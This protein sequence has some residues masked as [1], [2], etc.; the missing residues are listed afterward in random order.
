MPID[1]PAKVLLMIVFLSS[2]FSCNNQKPD[3]KN[4]YGTSTGNSPA[5]TVSYIANNGIE[6][7][8]PEHK[9]IFASVQCKGFIESR[10]EA[11]VAV[12][13]PLGGFVKK[14]FFSPGQTVKKGDTL[15]IL[16]HID[17][18][19]L[20]QEF[21]VTK[22]LYEYHKEAF[23]RQGELTVENASSIKKMQ[24]SQTDF[25][26]TE[27]NLTSLAKQLLLLGINPDSLSVENMQP[28]IFLKSPAHGFVSEYT[29]LIGRFVTSEDIICEI[30]NPAKLQLH[31]QIPP[32]EMSKIKPG[33]I[34]Y[35]R[36]ISDNSLKYHASIKIYLR[37]VSDETNT[38]TAIAPVEPGNGLYPGASVN[39]DIIL[40]EDTVLAVP[41]GAVFSKNNKMYLFARLDTMY[42]ARE[43]RTGIGN[44]EYIE[45]IDPQGTILNSDII[46]SDIENLIQE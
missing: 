1:N 18:I 38:C 3:N 44:S 37:S 4:N 26:A 22:S 36:S 23:K 42:K 27:V 29:P 46:F 9:S 2:V 5:F 35:F 19:K 21:L 34:V 15:A 43:V 20:Q 17:Y 6:T 24:Q 33:Q 16:E 25:L 13:A 10:P 45:I 14:I 12:S 41:S 11:I 28:V 40:Y 30:V 39:A 32:G 31:L 8:K 7:G